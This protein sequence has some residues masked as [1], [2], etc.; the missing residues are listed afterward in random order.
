LEPVRRGLYCG[1]IGYLSFNGDAD[2]NI[3]IRTLVFSGD[4]IYLQVGGGITIDSDPAAEYTET[5]D[6][7]RALVRALRLEGVLD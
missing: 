3:V 6:K 4:N 1:S 5:L 7:A 2:L